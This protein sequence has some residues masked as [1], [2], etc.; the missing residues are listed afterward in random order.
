MHPDMENETKLRKIDWLINQL[1][2]QDQNYA[3]WGIIS[4]DITPQKDI[5]MGMRDLGKVQSLV[6]NGWV[7]LPIGTKE[8]LTIACGPLVEQGTINY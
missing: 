2:I 7:V 6:E 8:P 3:R 1:A 4:C 5:V